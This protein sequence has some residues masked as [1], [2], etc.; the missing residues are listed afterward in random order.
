MSSS[1]RR[2]RAVPVAVAALL[3]LG[4]CTT[5][6]EEAGEDP[7]VVSRE[8]SPEGSPSSGPDASDEP[9]GSAPE[10]PGFWF[11]PTVLAPVLMGFDPNVAIFFSGIATLLFFVITRGQLPSYLGSSFAFIG[12]VIAAT[13]YAGTGPNANLPVALGGT[14][15]T[16]EGVRAALQPLLDD[17][18]HA[19]NRIGIGLQVSG[20]ADVDRSFFAAVPSV[21]L[22]EHFATAPVPSPAPN[23]LVL[24][25]PSPG[26][27]R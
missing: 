10:G 27:S 3:V 19:T 6:S 18:T 15:P 7:V 26:G 22:Q 14:A 5:G 21:W 20:P 11:P 2:L 23:A 17:P 24:R 8:P 9:S 1:A 16:P 12:V 4:A 13:G 25:I